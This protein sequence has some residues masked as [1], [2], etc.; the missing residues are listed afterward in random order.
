MEPPSATQVLGQFLLVSLLVERIMAV[1]GKLLLRKARSTA[2][3]AL[4]PPTDPWE[5]WTKLQV[6]S[7][8]LIALAICYLYQLDFFSKLLL[9]KNP[10]STD[11]PTLLTYFGF[12][13]SSV[14]IA[15]GS[16]GIQKI[17][18]TITASAKASKAEAIARL[19]EARIRIVASKA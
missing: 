14:V 16:S 7:A 10:G 3:V 15:G 17:L 5:S 4:D 18:A 1:G 9:P 11:A 19:L 12:F 8:F 2:E 13:L 6:V